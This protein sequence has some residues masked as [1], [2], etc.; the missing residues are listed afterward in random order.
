M[1]ID[2]DLNCSSRTFV[3]NDLD[4]FE[5]VRHEPPEILGHVE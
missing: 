5:P 4:P 1:Q 3:V 2:L